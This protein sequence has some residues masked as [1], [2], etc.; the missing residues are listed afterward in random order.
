[1]R[2][3]NVLIGTLAIVVVVAAIGVVVYTLH[4]RAS[5]PGPDAPVA[6]VC[7]GPPDP[8]SGQGGGGI[9]PRN[10]CTPSFS[11]QDVADYVAHGANL[12][13][14]SSDGQPTVTQ[15]LFVT[16]GDLGRVSHDS[17][18]EAN[19]PGDLLVC[20]AGLR[21]T[22]YVSIPGEAPRPPTAP[23][24]LCSTHTP[25]TCLRWARAHR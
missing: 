5:Y 25:A 18:W 1:M 10:D 2:R 16:I 24:T 21:G 22:F 12:G 3:R 23:P 20:Y 11:Q 6:V 13:K 15:I 17:E 19:Y 4:T 14:I 7:P 8:V 9:R